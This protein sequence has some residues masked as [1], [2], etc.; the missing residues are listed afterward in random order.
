M[1]NSVEEVGAWS[2]LSKKERILVFME[3]KL[4]L[5]KHKC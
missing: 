3:N 1:E 5:V 2:D 4:F